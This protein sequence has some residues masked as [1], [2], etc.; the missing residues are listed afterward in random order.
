MNVFLVTLLI[1]Y[2]VLFGAKNV[3]MHIY[4]MFSHRRWYFQSD[5]MAVLDIIWVAGSVAVFVEVTGI[6]R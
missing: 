2:G 6:F 4:C 1:T 5:I 3:L